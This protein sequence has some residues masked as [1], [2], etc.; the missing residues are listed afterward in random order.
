MIDRECQRH[1]SIVRCEVEDLGR[2]LEDKGWRVE[3]WEGEGDEVG[4]GGE[5]GK[6]ECWR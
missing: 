5:H 3:V 6:R 2:T 1:C 4:Y